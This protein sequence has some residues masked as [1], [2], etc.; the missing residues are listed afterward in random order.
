MGR[1]AKKGQAWEAERGDFIAHRQSW[2]RTVGNKRGNQQGEW[3]DETHT[4]PRGRSQ[5]PER[6]S[7]PRPHPPSRAH[8]SPTAR[9]QAWI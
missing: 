5:D 9:R 8:H 1:E 3:E 4:I 6:Y 7:S 2:D